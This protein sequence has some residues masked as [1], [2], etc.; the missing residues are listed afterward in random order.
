[1]LQYDLNSTD[2]SIFQRY[3]QYLTFLSLLTL[4]VTHHLSDCQCF[5]KPSANGWRVITFNMN[6]M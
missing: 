4:A 3:T 1:V 2:S 6:L 5:D